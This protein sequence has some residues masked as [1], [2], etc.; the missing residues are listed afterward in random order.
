M[1]AIPISNG[2]NCTLNTGFDGL[3]NFFINGDGV[4]FT[5]SEGVIKTSFKGNSISFNAEGLMGMSLCG[6]KLLI[7]HKDD[8][9]SQFL[10]FDSNN[11]AA[12]YIKLNT[13]G[14][15]VVKEHATQKFQGSDY[16]DL[17][18]FSHWLWVK[19]YS[20]DGSR[21]FTLNDDS[22]ET[23]LSLTIGNDGQATLTKGT[24][25][26]Q[27]TESDNKQVLSLANNKTTIVIDGDGKIAI[28]AGSNDVAISCAKLNVNDGNLEVT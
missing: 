14:S 13:D 9:T 20:A 4:S 15:F 17:D 3:G 16:E 1:K 28:D 11:K 26:V 12:Q 7:N 19:T 8:G 10:R 2:A 24:V 23:Q 25:T 5:V 18:S 22:D 27:I 6:G 21:A